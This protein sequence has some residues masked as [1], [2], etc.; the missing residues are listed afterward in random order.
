MT[1]KHSLVI[2]GTK[3]IGRSLVRILADQ[4]HT[5]SVIARKAPKSNEQFGMHYWSCD[6][7]NGKKI[8]KTLAEIIKRN[9]K[10]NHLVFF[11]R[12]RDGGN[13]WSGE[14]ETSLTATKKV[15]EQVSDQLDSNHSSIVLVS[16]INSHLIT[17]DLPVSYHVAKAGLVQLARYY[18][19][20]LGPKGTRVNCVSPG[21]IVKEESNDFYSKNSDLKNFYSRIAP[22]RRIGTANEIA[23]VVAFL[24]SSKASLITGQEIIVDGGV[25]LQW[26]ESIA[27]QLKSKK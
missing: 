8:E 27:V 10:L 3:G 14:I 9:G 20:R 16:S 2:G 13:D 23:E 19:V 22:L 21:T 7:R 15:I 5:V 17:K 24:L 1:K 4:G 26:Q 11:Q 6:L 12:F 18:A 25:S